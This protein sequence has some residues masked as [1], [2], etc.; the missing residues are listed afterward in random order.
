MCDGGPSIQYSKVRKRDLAIKKPPCSAIGRRLFYRALILAI[1]TG[2]AFSSGV[3]SQTPDS[4]SKFRLAQGLEQAG[5]YDR[6]AALY[7]GLL[8]GDPGNVVLLDA[9]ERMW[10]QLKRYDQAIGLL[11]T[12]LLRAPADANLHAQL[13][14]VLYRAGREK[15]ADG[16]WE[17][18]I[19]AGPSNPGTYRLLAAVLAE[20]RLLDRAADAY[21]RGRK[22]T[23]DP[24]LFTLELAQLLS[25]TMNYAGAT[26]EYLR[27]LAKNPGQISFVQSRLSQITGR[28]EA[29]EAAEGVIRGALGDRSDLP[30]LQ[31]LGW[32]AMEGK[33]YDEAFGVYTKIDALAGARGNELYQFANHAAGDRAFAAAARAYQA[34]INVPV[35]A[36]VMPFARLGYASSVLE[37][38]AEADTFASPLR[39]T[40]A[41]E[42]VPLYG[43]AIRLFQKIIEDYPGTEFSARSWYKIGVVQSEKFQDREGAVASMRHVIDDAGAAPSLRVQAELMMG[44]VHVAR[45]DTAKAEKYFRAVEAS[46]VALPD[47]HDESVYLLAEIDYFAG[48]FDSA[49]QKLAGIVVNLKA[50]Y[51][52]D[53]LRLAAFLQENAGAAPEALGKYAG[54]EFLARQGKNTEA[55]AVLLSVIQS[56]PQAPL[57]DDALLRV[58][59]LQAS[60]G[61]FREASSSY[62][63]LLTEF[64][65][66]STELDR[67]EFALGE[68]YQYGL[69][70]HAGA[71]AAYERLLAEY[72]KS[73]L[74]ERARQRIRQLR[75]ESL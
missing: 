46:R 7:E 74:A 15:E 38:Q 51:A 10:M 68:V 42:A 3:L 5:E 39:G 27:W 2:P 60:A 28:P 73:I 6:A 33:N 47:G 9:V 71:Q 37:L 50:D 17:A 45:G 49:M 20:N 31:L 8:Q 30:L 21:R 13:G 22:A 12:R 32:L 61:F 67:A 65:D 55:I 66:R 36:G 34:A 64:R 56:Y 14:S 62:E 70:D 48:R 43:G 58:G 57:V 72:P 25:S 53:A 1:L 54:A 4:Q 69:R 52:N 24:D 40:P 23:N 26:G 59:E 41:T 63:R 29:R 16:E 18:A 19:A 11:R 75:G 35:A 44:K